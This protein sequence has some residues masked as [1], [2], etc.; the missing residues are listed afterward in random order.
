[1]RLE[2]VAAAPGGRLSQDR[3]GGGGD[4]Y[5]APQRRMKETL[6][7][8]P[9]GS[10]SP[11]RQARARRAF[12]IRQI[13]LRALTPPLVSAPPPSSGVIRPTGAERASGLP[14]APSGVSPGAWCTRCGP[15]RP[16]HP[17][18]PAHPSATPERFPADSLL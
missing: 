5:S 11:P 17:F 8:E 6:S 7:R 1:N 13:S 3:A 2:P 4:A 9:R 16:R 12:S 10:F 15:P 18:G 14:F